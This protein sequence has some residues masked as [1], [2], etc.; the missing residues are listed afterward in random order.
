MKSR[1]NPVEIER[2]ISI[3]YVD[4]RGVI[5]QPLTHNSAEDVINNYEEFDICNLRFR[6]PNNF[7]AG[8]LHN[9]FS[10]WEK[11]CTD[12]QVLEWIK[13][14]VN[15]T[16]FF[17]HFKGNFKGRHYD[18]D[19]PPS[20]LLPNAKICESHTQFITDT[21]IE[22]IR[23]GSLTLLGKIDECDPPYLVL[24]LTVEPNKPRLCHDE[25]YL[26]LWIKDSPFSLETLRDIP[27]LVQVGD[28][29]SSLDDKSGYDHILLDENSKKYFGVQFGGF[30]FVWNSIPFG[31]KASAYIYQMTGLVATGYCRSLGIPCLQYIDDRWIG[32]LLGKVDDKQ[33][34]IV[35]HENALKSLYVVCEV[36]IRLGYFINIDKSKFVPST[37]IRFLGMLVDSDRLAFVI[38]VDKIEKFLV[39]K[40]KILSEQEVE[41]NTLQKFAG[42]CISFLL[43]IPS[44][45]FY[46]KE[47][48]KAI[49]MAGKNSGR[50]TLSQ[51]LRNE[52]SHWTFLQG[53]K[54]CFPWR[55][56]KHFQVSMVTDSSLY[57]WGALVYSQERPTKFSDFWDKKDER[58]IHLKETQALINALR[59]I[60]GTVKDHRVDAYVD[61]MACVQAWELQRFKDLALN[62]LMKDLFNFTVEFNVDLRLSYIPSKENPADLLSRSLS[63]HDCMLNRDKFLLVDKT[64]GPHQIDLMSLDS[65]V[66]RDVN[67]LPL[68]HFTPFPTPGSSG[69]NVFSQTLCPSDNMY[70]FPPFVLVLPVL[71]LLRSQ[72]VKSC[73]MVVP[74]E[75]TK[76]VWWPLF[77]NSLVNHFILGK[78]GELGV[79]LLPS[80]QGFVPDK[81]GLRYELWAAKLSFD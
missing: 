22:R 12:K 69:V 80:K 46:T 55:S 31:F 16:Q 78:K 14:G 71:T 54:D 65:N 52:I 41:L 20:I 81:R 73:T 64:F 74:F 4:Y 33:C 59:S 66:M 17:R 42:K 37:V 8:S 7:T 68:C 50:V 13:N 60:S 53:W 21:L 27:R 62:E 72:K 36:L 79:L 2:R 26:N 58:P 28:L 43:A 29:M 49:G 45:K 32:Q 19:I 23:C 25:R 18:S 9:Y 3:D 75:D 38:P 40:D 77:Y 34:A 44:A 67:G 30:Y 61:N 63:A 11:I 1:F 76:P 10:E 35:R 6:N 47:V 56:E 51:D 24:P 48:N 39:L 57:K 70:V 5:S 15:V